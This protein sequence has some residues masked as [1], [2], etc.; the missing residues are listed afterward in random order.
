MI[1]PFWV[2]KALSAGWTDVHRHTVSPL[3]PV[4]CRV[5]MQPTDYLVFH[6]GVTLCRTLNDLPPGLLVTSQYLTLLFFS[7]S[8]VLQ[9][10]RDRVRFKLRPELKKN[11]ITN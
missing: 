1:D 2:I 4:S 11:L 9:Q 6:T 3:P 8:R 10:A 5:Y 7:V